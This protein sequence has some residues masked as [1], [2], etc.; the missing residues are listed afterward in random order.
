MLTTVGD[1]LKWNAMLDTRSL[2]ASF[3]DELETQGVLNDGRKIP[4]ALGLRVSKYRDLPEVAHGGSTAGYQTFLV[5]YPKAKV[6]VAV[7][8]NGTSPSATSIARSVTDEIFGPFPPPTPPES[9]NVPVE[10]LKKFV[11]LWR[12]E[13][14]HREARTTVDGSTLRVD[15]QPCGQS[16]M[17]SLQ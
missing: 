8:C 14:I 11:G 12:D 16:Q 6:S 2:G 13:K 5:R 15:G 1:W 9:F 3:V 7:M 17:E 4:Y 10:Q